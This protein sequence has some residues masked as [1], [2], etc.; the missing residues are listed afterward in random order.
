MSV[1]P[2]EQCVPSSACEPRLHGRR[3]ECEALERIVANVREGH[4]QVLIL[5]GEPGVGKTALLDHLV[6]R[7]LGCRIAR[8]AAVQS[9]MG[10]PFAGLHQLCAPFLDGLGR[11]PDPQRDALGA[12]FGLREGGPPDRFLVGLAVLGL[13]SEVAGER[14][15]ICV[16]DDAHWLDRA[17]TQALAFVVRHLVGDAVAIV[18]AV[19]EF[20]DEPDLAGLPERVIRGLT[21]SDARALLQSVVTGPLDERVRDRVVA[22]ARGNPSALLEFARGLTPEALAGGFGLLDTPALSG[23]VEQS[24]RRRLSPLPPATRCLLLVAAAEPF[25]DP[26]TIWRAAALL[27][28]E[29]EAAEPAAAAGLLALGGGQARFRH[30]LARSAVYRSAS[31]PERQTAHRVLAEACDSELDPDRRAWHRAHA[32]PGFDEAVAAELDRAVGRAQ[33]RGRLAEAAAF[34]KLAAELTPD[35]VRRGERA[36]AAAQAK[37][38]LGASDVALQVL[39]MANAAPLDPL[40]RARA[41]R[42]GAQIAADCGRGRDAPRMLLD[43]AKRLA[44]FDAGL[45]RETYTDALSAALSAGRLARRGTV[46]EVAEATR[47]TW[48]SPRASGAGDLL[49]DGL[50][51]PLGDARTAGTAML[52]QALSALRDGAVST[53]EGLRLFP[54]MCRVAPEVW[55]DES[56]LL[57]CTRLIDMT[58]S[59]GAL[60]LLPTALEWGAALRALVGDLTDARSMAEEAQVIARAIGRPHARYGSLVIAAWRGRPAEVTQLVAAPMDEMID[61][62]EGQWLTACEWASAVLHNGLGQYGE[63]FVAAER[64]SEQRLEL[65]WSSWANVELIEAAARL[66]KPERVASALQ[67]VTEAADASGSDWALGIRARSAALLSQGETAERLYGEAVRRLGRGHI[68]AE[69]AR[70]HLLYGEWLRRE[71]RRVDAREHLRL[72]HEML[73][74]LGFDAFAERARRELLA[75]GET[76]RKRTVETRDDLTAQEAHIARLAGE[77]RTNP[78]IGAQLF[79]SARTVEWHLRKVFTKLSISSRKELLGALSDS[80]SPMLAA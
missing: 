67:R 74:A 23:R 48:P 47:A 6:G 3:N 34:Q 20:G 64:A 75:T 28:I 11:L 41:E 30:P 43:A 45:S 32:T 4:S 65:A 19:D 26:V 7:A 10:L 33:A 77:G 62:G 13:L 63:A 9:E 15:L 56:W 55:D 17:S 60:G 37:Y 70:A 79:I 18:F 72:A 53:H 38:W 12:A 61:R 29:V 66:G 51:A 49:L 16:V 27:G 57:V 59:V 73:A 42:L 54:L 22:E 44:P 68:R 24:F 46:L 69:L 36:L 76:V 50:A 14:P 1:F 21:E 25:L 40:Q 31:P 58:R 35:P 78:E 71:R 5:R 8:V 52:K 80:E 39:G 2:V